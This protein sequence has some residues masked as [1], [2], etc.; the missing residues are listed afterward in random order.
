MTRLPK[1]NRTTAGLLSVAALPVASCSQRP[2]PPLYPVKGSAV[3]DGKPAA[4]AVLTFHRIGDPDKTNLPHAVVGTDGTFTVTTFVPGDGAA[5]GKYAVTVIWRKK[6][7]GR[8][9]DDAAGFVLPPRYLEADKSGL[10]A[11]VKDAPTELS[12][13]V[14]TK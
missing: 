9:D 13:F 1:A 5:A 6:G 3:C 14:L 10:T 12:P 8:G 11:D 2:G 4:G 7:K